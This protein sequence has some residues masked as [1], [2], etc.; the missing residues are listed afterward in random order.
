M[1]LRP[2]PAQ[3]LRDAP[4]H[5]PRRPMAK[6]GLA[7]RSLLDHSFHTSRSLPPQTRRSEVC[8]HVAGNTK[9]VS[10]WTPQLLFMASQLPGGKVCISHHVVLHECEDC[11]AAPLLGLALPLVKSNSNVGSRI[12]AGLKPGLLFDS[13]C[14]LG[15]VTR[16]FKSSVFSSGKWE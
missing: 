6:P 4:R 14:H 15:Q 12:R 1:T 8:A 13:R 3:P 5:A 11:P 16:P 9:W 10:V 7:A 2:H